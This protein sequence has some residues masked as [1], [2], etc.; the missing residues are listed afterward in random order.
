MKIGILGGTFNPVHL[1]H[2]II[3]EQARDKLDLD[4]VIFIPAGIPPHKDVGDLIAARYRYR[5]IAAAIKGNPVFEVCD[6]EMHRKGKSYSVETLGE[7]KKRFPRKTQF[8]F[9]IGSDTLNEL[10]TW[11]DPE[12]IFTLCRFA[13]VKRPKFTFRNL[14][15]GSVMID[16]FAI[17][18]SSSLIREKIAAGESFRYLVPEAV[19][20]YILKNGLY[21]KGS[22]ESG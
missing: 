9:I 21:F 19:R 10:H 15:P 11:K 17:N 20:V 2:L 16:E 4:K 1:G 6:L 5:M 8:Y 3:A 13:V 22:P 14:P 7:L 12:R 18:I